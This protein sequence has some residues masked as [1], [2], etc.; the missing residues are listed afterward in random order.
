MTNKKL[1]FSS[2]E[3]F[4]KYAARILKEELSKVL[5]AEEEKKQEKIKIDPRKRFATTQKT[6][7][8]GREEEIEKD[9]ERKGEKTGE[10]LEKE[11]EEATKRKKDIE[12]LQR[13]GV[14]GGEEAWNPNLGFIK[15]EKQKYPDLYQTQLGGGE[16]EVTQEIEYDP[17]APVAELE[18]L[19]LTPSEIGRIQKWKKSGSEKSG[20]R[21]PRV[22]RKMPVQ[23]KGIPLERPS[24]EDLVRI[25]KGEKEEV[26]SF[27]RGKEG[28]EGPVRDLPPSIASIKKGGS[29]V[30]KIAKDYTFP[31]RLRMDYEDAEEFVELENIKTLGQFKQLLKRELLNPKS[32]EFGLKP[33]FMTMI[34]DIKDL[35]KGTDAPVEKSW[36]KNMTASELLDFV[37][38][39]QA[40]LKG[41]SF[42][43]FV[44][45]FSDVP[46]AELY[47][48]EMDLGKHSFR[49]RGIGKATSFPEKEGDI[50]PIIPSGEEQLRAK[51]KKEQER[52]EKIATELGIASGGVSM[53]KDTGLSKLDQAR[54]KSFLKK[55][56]MVAPQ[57]ADLIIDLFLT[58]EPLKDKKGKVVETE[59]QLYGRMYQ[60][61]VRMMVQQKLAAHHLND[62]ITGGKIGAKQ[63]PEKSLV[64]LL[65]NFDD[66]YEKNK[67][68]LADPKNKTDLLVME[69]AGEERDALMSVYEKAAELYLDPDLD[70]E[71]AREELTA[72]INDNIGSLYGVRE[73]I[74]QTVAPKGKGK[75]PETKYASQDDD[76][77]GFAKYQQ[78]QKA[79]KE[80]YS[81]KLKKE[82]EE[83]AREQAAIDAKIAARKAREQK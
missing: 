78:D 76:S 61:F 5:L 3:E 66:L 35:S 7:D 63:L 23:T 38:Q 57:V 52:L 28:P 30:E 67:D 48:P 33:E 73:K 39:N 26:G 69:L 43:Q 58:T 64:Q 19:G 65:L 50:A 34:V 60:D 56:Q 9:I 77:V 68:S 71:T 47:D 24:A 25:E 81:A 20:A 1:T 82:K 12:G 59:E 62:I 13:G 31:D 42:K 55:A 79:A 10:E 46:I 21:P 83:L 2:K 72:Y 18:R 54:N 53:A 29:A 11:R 4:K 45:Q 44:R 80:K 36:V 75:G 49:L 51:N 17:N 41:G 74:S 27:A 70:E 15:R 16:K 8:I 22:I 32:N 6:T 37:M 14:A 40:A